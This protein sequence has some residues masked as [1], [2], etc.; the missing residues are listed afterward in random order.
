MKSSSVS[1]RP[2][3]L[4]AADQRITYYAAL[5]QGAQSSS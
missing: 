2:L 5:H 1:Q 3:I 4:L